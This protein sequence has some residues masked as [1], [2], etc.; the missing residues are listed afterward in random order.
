MRLAMIAFALAGCAY[1]PY[2]VERDPTFVPTSISIAEVSAPCAP[3]RLLG[4]ATVDQAGH[5]RVEIRKYLP[6]A[7][8]RCVATHEIQHC[9][10]KHHPIDGG[11]HG[12][13]IDCGDGTMR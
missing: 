4:C 9:F 1:D 7:L 12:F 8:R 3:E 11:G 6:A 5:C 2:W 10:K 13:V